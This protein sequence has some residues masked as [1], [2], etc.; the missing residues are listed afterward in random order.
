MNGTIKWREYLKQISN[1]P[2]GK[3]TGKSKASLR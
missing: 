3:Y 1:I 2:N